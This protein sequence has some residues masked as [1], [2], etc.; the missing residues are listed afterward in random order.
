MGARKRLTGEVV[1]NAMDK[2]VVVK[3]VRISEHPLYR[4]K[5][6]KASRFS[7]HDENGICAVGDRVLIEETRPL[8]KTKRWRIVTVLQKTRVEGGEEVDSVENYA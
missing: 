4:K 7:A 5:I 1:S 3:V 2:T 8:S 6:R